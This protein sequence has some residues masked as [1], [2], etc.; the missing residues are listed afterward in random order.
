MTV[1]VSGYGSNKIQTGEEGINDR[2]GETPVA[3]KKTEIVKVDTAAGSRSYNRLDMQ[4]SQ[5]LHMAIEL[6]D[7]LNYLLILDHYDDIT[8]FDLDADPLVVS[9]YQMKTS[10]DTITIDSAISEDWLAKLYAQFNRPEGWLVKELGL[11]TNTPLE[12]S[13]K[14]IS[15]KGKPYNKKDSITAERTVF[16]KLHQSIQDKIKADIAQKLGIP[17]EQV[18]LSKF[19]HLHTTLTIE[20]HK[21]IIEKE[22]QDFLYEKYPRIT[23]DTV[24]GIYSSLVDLLTKRQEYEHVPEDAELDEVKRHK[25]FTRTELTRVIDK[26][27][28]L[29]LP[30]FEEVK[31]VSGV[32]PEMYTRLSFPYV[33]ILTDSNNKCDESFPTLCNATLE[34]MNKNPYGGQ[35][36]PWEYGQA[37]GHGVHK[38]VPLMKTI[39]NEDY[40]AIL[41]ICLL[42]N[43]TRRKP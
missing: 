24:K 22:V 17:I 33:Q 27:I 41:T 7:S 3:K 1:L 29:S 25:G 13:Y 26:A 15:K 35:G 32:G 6:Y 12:V 9:Y 20:R 11:I 43:E 40:I 21:D 2:K 23:V 28:M 37:I 4:V 19:A 42:I 38:R 34:E 14:V 36:T 31:K 39:Y 16:S 10:E 8:L 18:D 30:T 5:T